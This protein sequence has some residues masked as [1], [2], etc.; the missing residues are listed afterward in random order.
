MP[1]QTVAVVAVPGVQP[2]E[3]GVAWEGFGVDR[4]DDGIPSYDTRWVAMTR[5]GTDRRPAG[6]SALSTAS[7]TPPRRPGGHPRLRP[8]DRRSLGNRRSSRSWS[9]S[10]HTVERGATVMSLC[11]GAFILGAAGVLDGRDCTT[12]WRYAAELAATAPGA[13]GGPQRAV[14]LR[15][16][17]A[18]L[19]GHGRRA[20]PVPA[21]DPGRPRRGD[22]P[23]GRPPHG[24]AA[25]PRRRQAQ[26]V[27]VPI[28]TRAPTRWHR[29]S[30][31]LL[32]TLRPE[33]T[34]ESLAA[35]AP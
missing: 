21:R 10:A 3:L 23:Q 16:A 29:C 33:H 31:E 1:I 12:H 2:F 35:C 30:I 13:Q 19:G 20:R 22:R 18:H 7:T 24:H 34:I 26:Y 4:T 6:R 11:S 27:D 9:C 25:A 5:D 15:R 28:R 8:P 32:D 14:R 17:G